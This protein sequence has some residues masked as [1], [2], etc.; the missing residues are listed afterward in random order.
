MVVLFAYLIKPEHLNKERS[1]KNST[2]KVT[3][4]LYLTDLL[5]PINKM[6]DKGTLHKHI[7]L[8]RVGS[9]AYDG[10]VISLFLAFCPLKTTVFMLIYMALTAQLKAVFIYLEVCKD[11]T[12]NMTC[13]FF[14]NYYVIMRCPGTFAL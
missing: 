11:V 8:K 12:L 13:P 10:T 9:V 2:K 1:Y 5:N 7:K 6:L 14:V 3:L 4:L